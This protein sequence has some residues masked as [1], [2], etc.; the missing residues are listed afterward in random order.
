MTQV[1]LHCGQQSG[2]AMPLRCLKMSMKF[3]LPVSIP[4]DVVQ[5]TGTK[6]L[7]PAGNGTA[8]SKLS[9]EARA[10]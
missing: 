4:R 2:L 5:S 1:D 8:N 6:I 3:I 10:E 7:R 9:A